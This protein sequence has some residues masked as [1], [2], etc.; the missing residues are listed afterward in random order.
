MGNDI[1]VA[2]D[3]YEIEIVVLSACIS[4]S[5]SILGTSKRISSSAQ[6][7]ARRKQLAPSRQNH[8]LV[9]KFE[10]T[11]KKS[12]RRREIHTPRLLMHL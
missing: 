1:P 12:V 11:K 4:I 8:Q 10:T 9:S 5:C 2:E 3:A 6:Y 7:D